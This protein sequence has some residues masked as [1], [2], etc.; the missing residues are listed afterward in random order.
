M[1]QARIA[2]HKRRWVLWAIYPRQMKDKIRAI[3]Q[4]RQFIYGVSAGKAAHLYI[5]A[6]REM[7]LQVFAHKAIGTRDQNSWHDL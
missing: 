4:R 3:E 6:F 5:F 7:Q 1:R 2:H